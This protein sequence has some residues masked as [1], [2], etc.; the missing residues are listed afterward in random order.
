MTF[1]TSLTENI[2]G[3]LQ[4]NSS[5]KFA[6]NRSDNYATNNFKVISSFL[7][8]ESTSFTYLSNSFILN[9]ADSS[10]AK[11]ILSLIDFMEV[12]IFSDRKR[13]TQVL[14]NIERISFYIQNDPSQDKEYQFKLREFIVSN[15][16]YSFKITKVSKDS[17]KKDFNH[18]F[19]RE[20]RGNKVFIEF[21][22]ME[23]FEFSQVYK[24]ILSH[25]DKVF[26]DKTDMSIKEITME[27]LNTGHIQTIIEMVEV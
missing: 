13:T 3:F 1:K 21:L 25:Y 10:I 6:F 24:L 9:K 19:K 7:Q 16:F 8:A 14:D 4:Q 26:K 5:G 23:D 27:D 12:N 15:D 17:N 11:Q 2:R 22:F 20:R 18:D